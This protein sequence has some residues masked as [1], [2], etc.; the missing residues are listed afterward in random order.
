MRARE[1]SRLV[2]HHPL[3]S[4]LD[5]ATD[6]IAIPNVTDVAFSPEVI[7]PLLL[8]ERYGRQCRKLTRQ[9]H[10]VRVN[11]GISRLEQKG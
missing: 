9:F 2:H 3:E 5:W 4:C 11:H 6:C 1:L 7:S 8:P 10:M